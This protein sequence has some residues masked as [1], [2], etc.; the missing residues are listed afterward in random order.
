[1]VVYELADA[2]QRWRKSCAVWLTT[3]TSCVSAQS[4]DEALPSIS[5]H[6]NQT[7]KDTN[8]FNEVSHFARAARSDVDDLAP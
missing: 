2:R 5:R 6:E 4:P 1:M 8:S 3:F 7:I